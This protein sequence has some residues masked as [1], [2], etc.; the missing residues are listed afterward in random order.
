[1]QQA[2][3]CR[4]VIRPTRPPCLAPSPGRWWSRRRG[5]ACS[6]GRTSGF[7]ER[8]Q[9]P[10]PGRGACTLQ[11]GV[12]DSD[13]QTSPRHPRR[14]AAFYLAI[15]RRAPLPAQWYG[16]PI[17][18]SLAA[19]RGLICKLRVSLVR[20][21][22]N[23]RSQKHANSMNIPPI[24][25]FKLYDV[26]IPRQAKGFVYNGRRGIFPHM[27]G[28]SLINFSCL[29]KRKHGDKPARR[30]KGLTLYGQLP[31]FWR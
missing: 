24:L 30:D 11:R 27:T 16:A 23:F 9:P 28:R 14:G 13:V 2:V 26:I 19:H 6:S 18:K 15:R 31:K 29:W 22:R 21:H 25:Q 8:R 5:R 20:C 7:V 1:M 10:Q 3:P 12:V 17:P 4:A